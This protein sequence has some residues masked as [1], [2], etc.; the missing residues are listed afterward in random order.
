MR[1]G[2]SRFADYCRQITNLT[3]A[4][5]LTRCRIENAK[6]MLLHDSGTNITEIALSCG[7]QTSQYFATVFKRHLGLTPREFRRKSPRDKGDCL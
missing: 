6:R 1:F 4:E 2:R 7:F 3:P 5:Y